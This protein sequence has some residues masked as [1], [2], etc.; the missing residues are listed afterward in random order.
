M[1]SIQQDG[2]RLWKNRGCGP[3]VG[4]RGYVG[5]LARDETAGGPRQLAAER[6]ARA[7]DARA[8]GA[9]WSVE[10]GGRRGGGAVV[11]RRR[12]G[13]GLVGAREACIETF[14]QTRSLQC[15]AARQQRREPRAVWRDPSARA[16]GRE[17]RKAKWAAMAWSCPGC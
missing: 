17:R 12:E 1:T 3:V 6:L 9:G 2:C 4:H 8:G 5:R 13:G 15:R 14:Q 7:L 16:G 11:V 10:D